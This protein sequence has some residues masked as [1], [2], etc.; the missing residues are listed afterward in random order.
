M[1]ADIL[2]IFLNEA[3]PYYAFDMLIMLTIIIVG[4]AA[5]G[6]LLVEAV[7]KSTKKL[8]RKYRRNK[9]QNSR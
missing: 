3:S 5:V 2:N 7:V 1:L 4:I 6:M 9:V 8:T